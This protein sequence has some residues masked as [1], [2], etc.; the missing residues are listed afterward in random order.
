MKRW[1]WLGLFGLIACK[2]KPPPTQAAQVCPGTSEESLPSTAEAAL[3]QATEDVLVTFKPRASAMSAAAAT[4]DFAAGLERSGAIVKH[5][6]PRLRTVS[7]RMTPAALAA[8]KNNPDVESV[9]PNRP[10]HALGLSPG[11]PPTSLMGV[12]TRNSVGHVGEYTEGLKMVQAPQ[13]WDANNDGVFD[14]GRPTGAGITVC[15]IDSGWDNR[16]PELQAAYVG[17]KDFVDNDDNPLDQKVDVTGTVTWGGGHGTHVAGTIAAQLAAGGHVLP[18]QD[19]NGVV[20][21]APGVSLLVARV[22]DVKGNGS[23]ADVIAAVQ[24]C[25]DQHANIA[26]LSLGSPEPSDKEKAVFEAVWEGGKGMLSIAASGNAGSDDPAQ[27]QPI[28]YPAAY[29]TVMAVGAVD[30]TGKHASFSQYGPQLSVVGPGVNVLSSVIIDSAS[31][32]DIASGGARFPSTPLE[33]T[34]VGSY[35]G[36]LVNCGVGDSI[37]AC[38]TEAT[39][40]GFVAYVDRGGGVFFEDKARNAIQAGAHAVIIGNND[41]DDGAGNFTLTNPSRIWVPTSSVSLASAQTIKG[42]FGQQVTVDIN[43][44]DYQRETGTSMATP[45]VSGVA[46]LVWSSRPSLTAQQVRTVLENS[47]KR[48]DSPGVPLHDDKFG[49]G[50]VQALDAINKAAAL[51]A[52]TP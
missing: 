19:P 41:G 2:D 5:R 40:D 10:V 48:D 14:D 1:L 45:H 3:T 37:H 16:Q 12:T 11:L 34:G 4:T 50:L 20:G 27:S 26:S 8:L 49:W 47:A 29:D 15:V 24:W 52:S 44:V 25:H 51:P 21:V 17:G 13:V 39:C 31:Y 22:L 36:R 18:G 38:G 42:L 6:F 33:Y 35:T 23:T 46:A 28:S 9:E 30:M 7:A 32:A 43:G